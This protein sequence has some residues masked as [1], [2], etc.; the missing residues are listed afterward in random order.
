[1]IPGQ[2]CGEE[3][4]ASA[5]TCI[6]CNGTGHRPF[7][8]AIP[9]L[10]YECGDCAG[11]GWVWPGPRI[12]PIRELEKL[13]VEP[14]PLNP[15][16]PAD[17]GAPE[18]KDIEMPRNTKQQYDYCR[19]HLKAAKDNLRLARHYIKLERQGSCGETID[20]IQRLE[21]QVSDLSDVVAKRIKELQ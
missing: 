12:I 15:A 5:I 9:L 19:A 16:E 14:I 21:D 3:R 17:I 20:D 8:G 2:K 7:N 4:P 6:T 18:F 13:V 10:T 11:R 1:M